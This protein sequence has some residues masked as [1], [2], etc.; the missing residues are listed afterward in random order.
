MRVANKPG[1]KGRAP[2]PGGREPLLNAFAK[3][4]VYGNVVL[5][6]GHES[7]LRIPA[8]NEVDGN[9]NLLK[10]RDC[11]GDMNRWLEWLKN[12]YFVGT[13]KYQLKNFYVDL[14]QNE[15]IPQLE[16]EDINSEIVKL[17]KSKAFRVILT[18]TF[19]PLV[20]QIME[21]A[22][23]G[24]GSIDV[25][26]FGDRQQKDFASIDKIVLSNDIKPTLYYL[27]G[28]ATNNVSDYG[29]PQFIVDEEDYIKMIKDWMVSPPKSLMQFLQGKRILAIGCKFENW[30]FRFFWRAVL[31]AQTSYESK[32]LLALTLT[33]SPEDVQLNKVLELYNLT[34]P[35]N[36]EEFLNGLNE[37]IETQKQKA[38]IES[39]REGGI[40]I[41]YYNED[42]E[43][44]L[45]LFYRLTEMGFNVWMDNN[46]LYYGVEYKEMIKEAIDRCIV[47]IPILSGKICKHNA[48]KNPDDEQDPDFRFYRDIE[49]RRAKHRCENKKKENSFFILP[50]ALDDYNPRQ[51]DVPWEVKSNYPEVFEKTIADYNNA[52]FIQFVQILKKK[53]GYEE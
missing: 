17:I 18:T 28:K 53:L 29:N 19:N 46:N 6:L 43:D 26:N 34:N 12:E 11:N 2:L 22:W 30:L 1:E 36:V 21:D 47:F 49:W 50:F 9:E 32:H 31:E 37:A 35:G 14:P 39:R 7:L 27:F 5:L 40:F 48:A 23:G 44:A 10:L 41:S 45:S 16:P 20:E 15:Y 24:K 52:G 33:E 13:T 4:I 38:W 3:E 25:K 51:N 8:L 42:K